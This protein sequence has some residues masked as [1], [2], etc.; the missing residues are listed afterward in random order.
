MPKLP[1]LPSVHD[2]I[3]RLSTH[4]KVLTNLGKYR[5][6]KTFAGIRRDRTSSLVT[7]SAELAKGRIFTN[8]FARQLLSDILHTHAYATTY[9]GFY[10]SVSIRYKLLIS[11][12]I[13]NTPVNQIIEVSPKYVSTAPK[14]GIQFKLDQDKVYY[15]NP[16]T[17]IS[18]LYGFK[19]LI[20]TI[21]EANIV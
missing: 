7:Y 3:Q 21:P 2:A 1:V 10:E 13:N 14:S 5:G 11:T 18:Y 9:I 19:N 4:E 6:S 20:K 16:Y 17:F 8:F 15:L 12:K